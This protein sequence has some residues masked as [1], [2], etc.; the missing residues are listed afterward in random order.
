MKK[1]FIDTI[2]SNKNSKNT[3]NTPCK[4][5]SELKAGNLQA[6]E[7]IY[8]T[9]IQ[10]IYNYSRKLSNDEELIEDCIQDLFADIWKSRQNLGEVVS[11]QYYLYTA[12]KRKIIKERR[13][14]IKYLEDTIL[15]HEHQHEHTYSC[16]NDMISLEESKIQKKSIMAGLHSLNHVQRKAIILKFY[17]D[18]SYQEVAEKMSLK[19]GNVY[20]IISRGLKSL[21]TK[22]AK[23]SIDTY[24]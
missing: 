9:Y 16:E 4:L 3:P 8:N 21:E 10:I 20:K 23:A 1:K 11:I 15:F 18:L 13:K 2:F 6:F 19:V 12:I 24:E 17:Q 7:T 22:I 14:R 5:W